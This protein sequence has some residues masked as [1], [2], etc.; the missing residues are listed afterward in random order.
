MNCPLLRGFHYSGCY[1]IEST[2][3]LKIQTLSK[4]LESTRCAGTFYVRENPGPQGST[5]KTYG[6]TFIIIL[7]W[8]EASG[9]INGMKRWSVTD[10]AGRTEGQTDVKVEIVV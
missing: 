3:Y 7:F 5:P 4:L 2:L 6:A 9:A 10:A 8:V 1:Y